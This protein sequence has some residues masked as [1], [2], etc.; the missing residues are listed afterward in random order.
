MKFI[1]GG[2]IVLP[3]C[4]LE[5]KALL[6][7][8]KIIGMV[9]E[10]E[11]GKYKAADIIDAG[12][13]YILPG[14]VDI[15]IHGYMG[16]DVSDG[17]TEGITKM[18]EEIVKNGVTS[19]CPT[20]MTVSTD[21]IKKS[22]DVCRRLKENCGDKEKW[23]G[24]EILG[25][26]MEGPFINPSKKGAQNGE[27]ILKPDAGFV[28]D[29]KDIIKIITLAPEMEGAADAI[30]KI[31]EETDITVSLGHSDASFEDAV[32]GI[33]SGATH[34]THL[35]NAMSTIH[36]RTPGLAA[37]A[38]ADD[39]VSCELI[40][41]TFHISSHLFSLVERLKG[42]KLCL[43]TDCLRAAGLPEGEYILSGQKFIVKGIECRLEDGTIAGSILRL[44]KAIKNLMDHTNIPLYKAVAAASLNPARAISV[45]G[46]K[47]SLEIGKDADIVIADEDFEV[48]KTIIGGYVKYDKEEK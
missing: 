45:H 47:G 15:H 12:G 7:D 23:M 37:A 1:L 20:T 4:V 17:K 9:D 21:E 8:E 18:S 2:K 10:I 38:L 11:T 32:R 14:L 24:A 31:K 48:E 33:D 22:L 6:F 13:G 43:I 46:R 19:W 42:D 27:Y 5:R 36:H 34:V 30:K 40:A 25:V 3:D 29:N 35:F 39:R 28:I 26:H 41:D 16:E 44:N